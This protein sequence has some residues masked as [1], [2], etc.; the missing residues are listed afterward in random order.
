MKT[1][2][3]E[4]MAYGAALFYLGGDRERFIVRHPQLCQYMN[5]T[6]LKNLHKLQFKFI[7]EYM[8]NPGTYI[9]F[10]T[11]AGFLEFERPDTDTVEHMTRVKHF[12]FMREWLKVKTPLQMASVTDDTDKWKHTIVKKYDYATCIRFSPI[13]FAQSNEEL[14]GYLEKI[15]SVADNII[16]QNLVQPS[17]AELW[18]DKYAVAGNENQTITFQISK[19]NFFYK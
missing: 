8:Q 3:Y 12:N 17:R 5:A 9:N 11:G 4:K 10:G 14:N 7:E 18:I 1:V 13:E 16:I 6:L 2:D 19:N 15:F